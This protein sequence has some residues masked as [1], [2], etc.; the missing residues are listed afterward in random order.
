MTSH[1]SNLFILDLFLV[2]ID[3]MKASTFIFLK[4]IKVYIPKILFFIYLKQLFCSFY[5]Q[6]TKCF[7]IKNQIS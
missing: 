5:H 3:Y 7:S 1:M 2:Y 6:S 4:I